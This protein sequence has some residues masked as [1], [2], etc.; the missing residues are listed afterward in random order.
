MENIYI[1]IVSFLSQL[2]YGQFAIVHDVDG[3]VNVRKKANLKSEITGK[4]LHNEIV[5]LTDEDLTDTN[6]KYAFYETS[7]KEEITG[8]I[9]S[10]RL[11]ILSDFLKIDFFKTEDNVVVF[12]DD[13]EKI[14]IEIAI[15]SFNSQKNINYFS[16]KDGYYYAYKNKTVWG[17]DG[18]LPDRS[19][20]FVKVKIKGKHAQVPQSLLEN[21]F[22]PAS[23]QKTDDFTF[24]EINYDKKNDVLYIS[25]LNSDGAGSYVVLFVFEKG[26]FKEIKTIIPY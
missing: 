12:T 15:Q 24:I 11:K 5:Y 7:S 23:I 18:N 8:Y 16:S 21:L 4:V 19:Y 14:K 25:S 3:F 10:S 1:I 17:T 13:N 20:K 26:H 2:S 22:Q 9:H 6:W